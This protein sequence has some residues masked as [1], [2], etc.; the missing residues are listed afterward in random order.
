MPQIREM[1]EFGQLPRPE[2]WKTAGFRVAF[3]SLSKST[4]APCR[5]SLYTGNPSFAKVI[6]EVHRHR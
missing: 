6:C 3:Y 5:L 2:N 1:S 4:V